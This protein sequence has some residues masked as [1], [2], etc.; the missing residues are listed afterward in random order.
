MNPPVVT[1]IPHNKAEWARLAVDAY[2]KGHN[3]FG[4]RFSAL[5]ALPEGHALEPR[6]YDSI[7]RIYRAWLVFGWEEVLSLR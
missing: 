3:E 4:H 1:I 5:A 7:Q 6:V 2:A